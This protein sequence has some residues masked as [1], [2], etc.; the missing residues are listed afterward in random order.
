MI[1]AKTE[2][3]EMNT[4]FN[5]TANGRL[6]LGHLYL[7]LLNH[8]AARKAGGRFIVRFD[9]DQPYW[10]KRL[11]PHV[12]TGYCS[13]IRDDLEWAGLI[14]DRYSYESVERSANEGF[15]HGDLASLQHAQG[16]SP[17]PEILTCDRPYPYAPYLTAVKVVQDYREDCGLLIRGEDLVTEFSLY[18][19]FCRVLGFMVPR[20]QY[21]PKLECAGQDLSDV[22]KTAGNFKIADFRERGSSPAQV[23]ELLAESCLIDPAAGWRFEN[24]KPQPALPGDMPWV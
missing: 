4:R 18:L 22:S 24:V 6:H 10:L 12:V 5:P 13:M 11:G 21:V 14:A 16:V 17:T 20:F 23:V 9:D 1:V 2:K 8:H 3:R 19:Y 15:L 7:A